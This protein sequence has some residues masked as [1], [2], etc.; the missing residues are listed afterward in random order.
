[1][2]PLRIAAMISIMLVAWATQSFAYFDSSSLVMVVYDSETSVE[3]ATDLGTIGTDITRDYTGDP[4][5]LAAAG[6][7][8]TDLLG[9]GSWSD[10]NLGYVS[11]TSGTVS[12]RTYYFATTSTTAPGMQTAAKS[13]FQSGWSSLTG[14]YDDLGSTRQVVGSTSSLN[15]YTIKM[16]SGNTSP[17]AYANLNGDAANGET[18]LAA[19][20]TVGYVDMYLYQY[21]N[22]GVLNTGSDS[23]TPYIAILRLMADGSVWLMSVESTTVPIPASLLLFGTGLLG[24]FGL[25][26]KEAIA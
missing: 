13:N 8:T 5:Q 10:L 17:G 4:L 2:K 6:T 19:L 25:R 18:T 16:N 12:Q 11:Y 24:F 14:Y 22:S 15:S 9:G 26:R 21:S 23:E 20:A 3:V 1:M 7:I